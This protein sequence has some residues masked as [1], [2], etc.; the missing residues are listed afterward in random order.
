[1][2]SRT[3]AG[4]VPPAPGVG[5]APAVRDEFRSLDFSGDGNLQ[6]DEWQWSQRSFNRL[7]LNGDGVLSRREFSSAPA[8]AQR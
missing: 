4:I 1:M 3:A 6:K 2:G 8:P 7:D 5:N